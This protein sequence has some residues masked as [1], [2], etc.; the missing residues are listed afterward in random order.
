[1]RQSPPAR[2]RPRALQTPTQDRVPDRPAEAGPRGRHEVRQARCPL[3]KPPSNS[4]SYGSHCDH[5][6]NTAQFGEIPYEEVGRG[7]ALP[8]GHMVPL[9]EEDLAHLPLPTKRAFEVLGFVPGQNI[10]PITYG[11]P[12]YTVPVGPRAHR[13]YALLVEVLAR[14]GC[15]GVAKIAIRSREGLALLR[16]RHRVPVLQ[17]LLWED[18]LCEPGDLAP[19]VPVRTGNWSRPRS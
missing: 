3:R 5:I 6:S 4:P 11:K 7:F 1:M 15:V 9:T 17:T 16:P 19:S 14:T 8:D 18:G 13:P 2:L 10:A 12:Y